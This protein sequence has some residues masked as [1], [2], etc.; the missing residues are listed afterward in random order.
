MDRHV[1]V[2]MFVEKVLSKD[3]HWLAYHFTHYTS[4]HEHSLA[5]SI[6]DCCVNVESRIAGFSEKFSDKLASL[7]NSDKSLPHYEQIIQLLA[8]LLVFNHLCNVFSQDAEFIFEP[9]AVRD[10]KNPELGIK[11]KDKELYVEVKC[12]EYIKH[13]N[14]RAKAA[15][16]LPTRIPGFPEVAKDLIKEGETIVYP[17]D[18]SVKE[19]LIS[20]NGKFKD[21][22]ISNP[23][24][25]TVLVIV[26]DDFTY[27]AI[28]SLLS[29]SSGLLTD[30]SYY[31]NDDGSPIKFKYIDAIILI[32]HSH[33]IV[34][35]TR[36]EPLSENLSHPLE[37]ANPQKVL[38]N[39]YIPINTT[40]NI[41]EYLCELFQSC[42]IDGLSQIAADYKP[43]D[44]IFRL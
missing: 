27:E 4:G 26:W 24:A 40:R 37:W 11:T 2:N 44:I 22:K 31:R 43:Q 30:N 38:P 17:R 32:R 15:I 13:T 21:F 14:A 10:G 16:E 6:I 36:D 8:E 9:V 3:F 23:E 7:A 34:N 5:A 1:I 41:D 18:N 35:A 39:A 28:S 12:R 19:F 25:I 29:G 33:H 42:H 20:A